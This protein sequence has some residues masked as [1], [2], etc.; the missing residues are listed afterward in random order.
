MVVSPF[1][2]GTLAAL[3]LLVSVFSAAAQEGEPRPRVSIETSLGTIVVEL[4]NETPKHRDN[5]LKLAGEGFYDG[6][7]FHRVISGFM[8][9]GGDPNSKDATPGS[10]LGTGGP[11]YTIEAEIDPAFVHTKGALAAARQ[12]DQVNPPPQQRK[13]ILHRPGPA[14][15]PAVPA[16]HR[17]EQAQQHA[18]AVLLHA[19]SDCRLR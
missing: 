19:R 1:R 14:R 13:P 7:L 4:Y 2:T 16:E 5:F 10:R 11:G 8:A 18:P 9:Q 6:T 15:H 17:A 3:L 12:G